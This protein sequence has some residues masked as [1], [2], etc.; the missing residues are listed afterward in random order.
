MSERRAGG[1]RAALP[2][3]TGIPVPVKDLNM[4]AGV[5]VT[6]GSTLF[7]DNVAAEDDFVAAALR[8]AGTVMT[9]KTAAPEFGLPCYP[10]PESARRPARP[11][12]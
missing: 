10:R 3:L 1:V 11:G 4:V 5:R 12:I 2:P 7:A 6:Y 9:G 8:S